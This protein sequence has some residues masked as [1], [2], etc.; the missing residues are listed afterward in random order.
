MKKLLLITITALTLSS[1]ASIYDTY[2]MKGDINQYGKPDQ[3]S[4]YNNK[5]K[6]LTWYCV[7]GKYRSYDYEYTLYGWLRTDVYESNCIGGKR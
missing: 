5:T 1:C 3:E 2:Q 7:N 6:T 4:T